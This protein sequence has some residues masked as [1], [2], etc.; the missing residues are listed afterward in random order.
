MLNIKNFDVR[1]GHRKSRNILIWALHLAFLVRSDRYSISQ[2]KAN[3]LL[4][5]FPNLISN[6]DILK[7][8]I[9]NDVNQCMKFN[10]IQK[11]WYVYWEENEFLIIFN[12]CILF[13][14]YLNI[15]TFIIILFSLLLLFQ[16]IN[17][18]VV[19]K[20]MDLCGKFVILW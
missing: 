20:L 3:S 7:T 19:W 2:N 16:M 13:F 15:N 8:Y 10:G 6:H 17:V 1:N 18:F 14:F 5:R 11:L 4:S 12:C 9:L